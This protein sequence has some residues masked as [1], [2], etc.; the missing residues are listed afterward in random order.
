MT[1]TNEQTA[2]TPYTQTFREL[3]AE[4]GSLG[5]DPRHAEAWARL[6][7]GTLDHLS[8][9]ELRRFVGEMHEVL[10]QPGY[11]DQCESLARSYGL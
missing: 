4:T 1:R 2:R 9:A 7:W 10:T 11:R 3:L 5:A 8:R 6:E